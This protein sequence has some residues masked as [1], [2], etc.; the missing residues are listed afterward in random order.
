MLRR[1]LLGDKFWFKLGGD[2][3]KVGGTDIVLNILENASNYLKN[4]KRF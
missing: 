1:C 2:D 3:A 4:T